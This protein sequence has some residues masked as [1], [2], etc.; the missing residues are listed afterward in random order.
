MVKMNIAVTPVPVDEILALREAY[1]REMG[2]QIVHDSFAGRGASDAYLVHVGTSV[3]GYGLVA[4]RYDPDT[5]HEFYLAPESRAAALPAFHQLL[6]VSGATRIMAQS[7]DRLLTLMLYDCAVEIASSVILFEDAFTS[8]LPSPGGTLRRVTGADTERLRE[9]QLDGESDWMIER[10]GVPVA[11]GGVLFH[12]N[13]PYGDIYM[14]VAEPYRRR[15]FGSYLV[16]EMKR[17]CRAQGK[18]P[19]A[20]CNAANTASR[21]TLETAGLLPCARLLEGQV[22]RLPEAP[23]GHR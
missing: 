5:A 4:R 1:R 12:Y 19:A 8:R 20:R 2:C 15:G 22:A 16:Q 3:A 9:Q 13:P 7:N 14:Q 23:S 11:T 21:R 10:D 18:T 17:I 6:E